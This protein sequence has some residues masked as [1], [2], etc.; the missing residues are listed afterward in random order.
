M[1]A[2]VKIA[3]CSFAFFCTTSF[4]FAPEARALG[5]VSRSCAPFGAQES[6][7]VDWGLKNYWLWTASSHYRNGIFLHNTNTVSKGNNGWEFTWR[8]YAGHFRS[9]FYYGRVVGHHWGNDRGWFIFYGNTEAVD[10]NLRQ[11]GTA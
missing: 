11:W 9:E 10:C 4:V 8:S 6:I 2:T 1:N 5:F 7:S 3:L